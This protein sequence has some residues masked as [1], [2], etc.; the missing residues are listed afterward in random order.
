M[1]TVLEGPSPMLGQ[2]KTVHRTRVGLAGVGGPGPT[3]QSFRWV[4]MQPEWSFWTQQP[5][6]RS[7]SRSRSTS[8][9]ICWSFRMQG[10]NLAPR[11][12]KSIWG[13]G[14]VSLGPEL[15]TL[16]NFP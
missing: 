3:E 5:E 1:V 15:A 13:R 12:I 7:R 6:S 4:W 14:T 2:V 10:E 16:L 9:S 11:W 8:C